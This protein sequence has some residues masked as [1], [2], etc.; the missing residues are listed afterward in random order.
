MKS[1]NQVH[2]SWWNILEF[3]FGVI[4]ICTVNG[5]KYEAKMQYLVVV[6][7]ILNPLSWPIQLNK[8]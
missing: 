5:K 7:G 8:F 1:V 2:Y 6:V 3:C 4:F